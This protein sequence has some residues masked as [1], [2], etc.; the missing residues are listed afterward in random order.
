MKN[1][2]S[3]SLLIAATCVGSNAYAFPVGFLGDGSEEAFASQLDAQGFSLGVDYT[4][5]VALSN[6]SGS[7]VRFKNSLASDQAMILSNGHCLAS[8]LP[9]PEDVVVNQ[10]TRRRFRM[11]TTAGTAFLGSV[12]SDRLLYGTMKRTDVSLYR[13]N[14][15]FAAI[16]RQFGAKPLTLADQRP[17]DG[18]Q[19]RIASGYWKR[20]YFCAIDGFVNELREGGYRSFDSIRYSKPGCEVI[21]GTSGSPI[22][23]VETNEVIGVNNTGNENGERC[24]LNNPCE[25]DAAGN[26]TVDKGRGYGQQTFWIY[27]CLVGNNIDLDKPGCLLPKPKPAALWQVDETGEQAFENAAQ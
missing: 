9:A 27:T 24:T 22:I 19:I 17:S 6:C 12:Y 15:S 16:E 2:A 3:L 5:I 25:V 8:G 1:I 4:G 10:Q 7:L 18:T 20:T 11:L 14:L 13:L 23:S 26:E 21:G